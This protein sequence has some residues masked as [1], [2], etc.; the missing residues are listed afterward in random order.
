LGGGDADEAKPY[1]EKCLAINPQAGGAMNGLARVLKAQ[2]DLDG[3][4]KIWQ[5][6]VETIPG[7]HAGTYGLADAYLEKGEFAKAV[8]LLEQLAKSKP[9]D[10]E[11]QEKL[12]K[13]KTGGAE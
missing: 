9:T 7:P 2:D 3:A 1:F 13:A 10:T 4:I 5:E 6:M 8:P 12:A 11:I